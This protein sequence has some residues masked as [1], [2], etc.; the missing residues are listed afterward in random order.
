[1]IV[2]TTIVCRYFL[3]GFLV[4]SLATVDCKTLLR[5]IMTEL[6]LVQLCNVSMEITNEEAHPDHQISI[7]RS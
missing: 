3:E 2:A 5:T 6:F 7:H 1:M 4:Y